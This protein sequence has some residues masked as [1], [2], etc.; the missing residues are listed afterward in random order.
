MPANSCPHCQ[1]AWPAFLG[2]PIALP[3]CPHCRRPRAGSLFE[4]PDGDP[5]APVGASLEDLLSPDALNEL[6]HIPG[7]GVLEEHQLVDILEARP[8]SLL[9][10]TLRRGRAWPQLVWFFAAEDP[11][12]ILSLAKAVEFLMVLKD[13]SAPHV[14]QWDSDGSVPFLSMDL[15]EG[16]SLESALAGGGKLA[17]RAALSVW[18]MVLTS[19][20]R[21]HEGGLTASDIEPGHLVLHPSNRVILMGAGLGKRLWLAG[22]ALGD[23]PEAPWIAPEARFRGGHTPAADVWSATQILA[24]LCLGHPMTPGDIVDLY[25][26]RGEAVTLPAPV[27]QLLAVGLHP[28]PARRLGSPA[29]LLEAARGV[30]I[31]RDVIGRLT[32]PTLTQFAPTGEAEPAASTEERVAAADTQTWSS[33][34][35][36]REGVDDGIKE[37]EFEIQKVAAKKTFFDFLRTST[38]ATAAAVFSVVFMITAIQVAPA[39]K[40]RL[41]RPT[42]WCPITLIGKTEQGAPLYQAQTDG[43]QL[44]LVPAGKPTIGLTL[45]QA[46]SIQKD[47]LPGSVGLLEREVP[48][49]QVEVERPFLIDRLEVSNK[50]YQKFLAHILTT[51]DHS[52][53]HRSEPRGHNH[54][55]RIKAPWA[56]P[57]SWIGR[58]FPEGGADWPVVLVDW[59]DAYA[60]AAWAGMRLPTEVEWEYAARGADGRLWPWGNTWYGSRANSAERL[61]ESELPNWTF[62]NNWSLKWQRQE[63]ISRNTGTLTNTSSYMAGSS[64]FGVLDMAGNVWEWTFD[65]YYEG[66]RA[67]E[68]WSVRDKASNKTPKVIRGGAWCNMPLDLR[69]S[70]R[71]VVDAEVCQSF[72]G[73]RC[74]RDLEVNN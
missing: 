65:T 23:L 15:P 44:V 58:N 45:E 56:T 8:R 51:G 42:N 27:P 9:I 7:P 40:K 3:A 31:G 46:R 11:D 64:P 73:F 35:N 39:L 63:I 38:R 4:S 25:G 61:A 29:Q 72:I 69:T 34:G 22:P 50:R 26:G 17:P 52:R 49:Q 19:L 41:T 33:F 30:P 2:G 14:T 10:R 60:Y 13:Q 6:F 62:W 68:A 71:G 32:S 55:P 12:V 57:Y 18:T 43:A 36:L 1:Q 59:F 74:A 20:V 53:C 70:R 5:P 24:R 66:Y 21:L 37:Q 67:G 28:D 48:E 16:R 47:Y 54:I